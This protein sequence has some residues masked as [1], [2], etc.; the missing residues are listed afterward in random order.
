MFAVNNKDT[1]TMSMTMSMFSSVA[2]VEFEE[3]NVRW[4]GSSFF[5]C[6]FSGISCFGMNTYLLKFL[7]IWLEFLMKALLY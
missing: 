7:L 4:D 6:N 1:R 3:A 5:G 2:I